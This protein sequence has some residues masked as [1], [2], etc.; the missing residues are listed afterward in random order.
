MYEA[1]KGML[2]MLELQHEEYTNR[3]RTENKT[4]LFKQKIEVIMLEMGAED[5]RSTCG[6]YSIF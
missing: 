4:L 3:L 1:T 5:I 6:K 2:T